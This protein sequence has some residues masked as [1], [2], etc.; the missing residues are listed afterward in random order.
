VIER[1]G[2][3]YIRNNM[4]AIRPQTLTSDQAK[5]AYVT[6]L[7]SPSPRL[8]NLHLHKVISRKNSAEG[9]I[10]LGEWGTA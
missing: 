6:E 7:S 9:D 3:I 1:H 10:T 8:Y 4:S 2:T 5:L